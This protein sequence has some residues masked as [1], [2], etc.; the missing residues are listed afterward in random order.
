[1]NYAE[2]CALAPSASDG[3]TQARLYLNKVRN[4]VSLPD[5]NSSGTALFNDIINERRL[6]LAMEG[7][8]FWDMVRTG[9]AAAAF[10]GKGTFRAGVSDLLPIPQA[11]IDASGGVITQNPL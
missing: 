7:H 6:E 8:R 3:E 10:A 4:R 9:K 2:A 11:E 1:L 5:K